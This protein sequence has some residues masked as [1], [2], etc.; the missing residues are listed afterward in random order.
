[1]MESC[2]R[3]SGR[4]F[5]WDGMVLKLP[6]R[7]IMENRLFESISIETRHVITDIKMP[8]MDGIELAKQIRAQNKNVKILFLSG[9]A[10]FDYAKQALDLDVEDYI[11]KNEIN[12]ESLRQKMLELKSKIRLDEEK[13][14]LIQQKVLSEIFNSGKNTSEYL[15]SS[16]YTL[17]EFISGR[18]YYF[19][20]EEDLPIPLMLN[21]LPEQITENYYTY[22]VIESCMAFT[23][24]SVK[25]VGVSNIG[26]H[27]YIIVLAC[28]PDISSYNEVLRLKSYARK[29]QTELKNK[30]Q[31][32]FSI[33]IIT[34]R[35]KVDEAHGLYER[36]KEHIYCKYLLGTSLVCDIE[37][38]KLKGSTGIMLFDSI[39]MQ[40]MV[41]KQ[42]IDAIHKYIDE[43]FNNVIACKSYPGLVMLIKNLI[44]VLDKYGNNLKSIKSGKGFQSYTVAEKNLWYDAENMKKYMK[45]K[46]D[47]LLGIMI[48]NSKA[49]YSKEVLK[50]IEYIRK[51]YSNA[52]LSIKDIAE[53]VSLSPT[54]L[55][56]LFKA[57]TDHTILDFLTN[58]RIEKA[59]ELLSNFDY[60]VYEVCEMVGYGSSQYFSQVFLKLTGVKPLDYKKRGDYD[61]IKNR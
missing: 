55:S 18:Y 56:Y 48:E 24:N 41:E 59:K 34:R 4:L 5:D 1:M 49:K 15:H 58:Y 42:D 12:E 61:K 23:D 44:I 51:N 2:I 53:H 52:E 60:K 32:T 20:L 17:V 13:Y 28:T 46:F 19:I 36:K 14:H 10:E 22:E 43:L 25:P 16:D 45:K 33:F 8:V 3:G 6:V 35:M 31:R 39:Y 27:R 57:E 37:D 40:N 11:L 38:D 29:L 21:I 26:K 47:E 9:Y 7:Q 54:R 50:A 30:F